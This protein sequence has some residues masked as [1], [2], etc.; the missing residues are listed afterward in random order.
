MSYGLRSGDTRI[1]IINCMRTLVVLVIGFYD[2]FSI[3]LA[4]IYSEYAKAVRTVH[5]ESGNLLHYT[6]YAIKYS[7]FYDTCSMRII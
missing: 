4:H 6:P 7:T 3:F 2:Y 5:K 1:M